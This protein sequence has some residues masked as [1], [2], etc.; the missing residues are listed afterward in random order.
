MVRF[1]VRRGLPPPRL[2]AENGSESALV[3]K[4]LL[5]LFVHPVDAFRVSILFD[6]FFAK[7]EL[8][9]FRAAV[10]LFLGVRPL[11]ATYSKLKIWPKKH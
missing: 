6:L 9:A 2:D 4:S 7:I 11:S 10:G 8:E 1:L 5:R 3:G